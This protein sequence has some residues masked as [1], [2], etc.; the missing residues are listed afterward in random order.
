MPGAGTKIETPGGDVVALGP[1]R[2]GCSAQPGR[3]LIDS[4]S[5]TL[6]RLALL[7]PGAV[8]AVPL[9]GLNGSRRRPA[10]VTA[11]RTRTAS[12]VT[13]NLPCLKAL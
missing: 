6:R 12:R 2:R 13:S 3:A 9:M 11:I 4:S 8:R 5:Q 7:Q 10:A 1:A